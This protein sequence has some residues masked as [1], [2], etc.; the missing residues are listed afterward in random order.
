[1]PPS[2]LLVDK[3]LFC[4]PFTHLWLFRFC[5][6][7]ARPTALS[8]LKWAAYQGVRTGSTFSWRWILAA[9]NF[10]DHTLYSTIKHTSYLVQI[11]SHWRRHD[12]KSKDEE[13]TVENL[14]NALCSCLVCWFVVWWFIEFLK[15]DPERT[16]T[17][18]FPK[19]SCQNDAFTH[20][21]PHARA[22]GARTSGSLPPW[23]R[24]WAYASTA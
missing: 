11:I 10:H 5:Q 18:A 2:T 1:M 4:S 14:F 16:S 12:P 23:R 3:S 13:E 20:R 7:C 17:N 15:T 8:A 6:F 19:R 22:D 24:I 9:H 21:L